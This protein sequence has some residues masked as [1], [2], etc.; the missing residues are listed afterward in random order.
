MRTTATV[1]RFIFQVTNSSPTL[2]LVEMTTRFASSH[3]SLA[4]LVD[5]LHLGALI[6]LEG[7]HVIVIL[8]VVNNVILIDAKPKLDHPVDATSEGGRLVK[9][10]PRGEEGGVEQEPDEVLDSLVV[11]VLVGT[12]AESVDDGVRRVDLHRLL[13]C[14]VAGHGAVLEGLGLHDTL[15]VGR[16]AV[17]AG[18][19]AAWG[20][21]QTVGNNNLLGLVA[22]HLLDQLAQVLAGSLLLLPLL[23]LLVGLLDVEAFLGDVKDLLAIILLELLDGVL[24]NWV[25]HVKN[26]ES[27]LLEGLKEWRSLDD[28]LGLASDAVDLLLVLLHAGDVVLKAGHVLTR[29]ARGVTHQVSKLV[30]VLAVLMHTKLHVLAELLP[31]LVVVLGI[32]SNLVEHLDGLL[33]QVLLD[34]LEDL[35]ALQHLTGDVERKVLGVN[36]ALDEGEELGDK[37]LAVV[38]DEHTTHVQLDVGALLGWL[39]HVKGSTLGHKQDRLE[40]KLALN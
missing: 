22:K 7:G 12:S 33:D 16:P 21:G 5:L 10:E 40:L 4:Q 26:L 23:L 3:V 15:H 34:D 2:K 39:E 13:G 20:V 28:L 24:I 6:V 36:N 1:C 19:K 35:R 38:G 18:H 32:L 29:L 31:E 8:I 30:A 9:S 37:L 27:L 11:L 14:H 25:N 17:L